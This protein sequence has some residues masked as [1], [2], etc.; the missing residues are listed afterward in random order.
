[1]GI[2]QAP[3][4]YF[5]LKTLAKTM[6]LSSI[7]VIKTANTDIESHWFRSIGP[8]DLYYWKTKTKIVKHQ[9]SLFNQ[10]IEWNEYDGVKTGFVT[11][12]A[13]VRQA[14]VIC[15]D[16]EVNVSVT[17]QAIELLENV[18]CIEAEILD[19]LIS[20]Y[21]FYNRWQHLKAWGLIKAFSSGF[22]KKQ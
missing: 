21:K 6:K 2:R 11:H 4:Q 14:E 15:F 9:V 3:L 12:E 10:I 20:H 19:K 5:D 22:G 16:E 17:K 7:D 13:S 8:A 1:M 18:G